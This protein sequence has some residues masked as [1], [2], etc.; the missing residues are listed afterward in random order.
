MQ[1]SWADM[2]FLSLALL[3]TYSNLPPFMGLNVVVVSGFG[4]E[5][6]SNAVLLTF[7]FLSILFLPNYCITSK[8]LCRGIKTMYRVEVGMTGHIVHHLLQ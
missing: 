2:T 3:L 1:M 5:E 4:G 7:Q 6:K 8:K